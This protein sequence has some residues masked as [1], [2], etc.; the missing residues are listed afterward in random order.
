MGNR[1]DKTEGV[2]YCEGCSVKILIQVEPGMGEEAIKDGYPSAVKFLEDV[3]SCP[4]CGNDLTR[5][6]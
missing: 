6:E 1:T 4:V 3:D 2:F 5:E